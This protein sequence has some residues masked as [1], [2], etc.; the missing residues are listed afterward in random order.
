MKKTT[1]RRMDL[2]F[3]IILMMLSVWIMINCV[4]MFFNPFGREFAR[5]SGEDI[6]DSILNW[7]L[8]PAL[9]PF[10]F[11]CCLM[12][13]AIALYKIA[14]AN[15]LL[16]N[17]EMHVAVLVIAILTIY[18][19]GLIP[20]CRAALDIFPT[21]QGFPFMIATF[22]CLVAQMIVFSKKNAKKMIAAV[23][24]AAIA[25]AAVTYGFGTLA[26]IPLP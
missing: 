13:C 6:K 4:K 7:Y 15:G 5:V 1:L 18:I 26:M 22:V 23:V 21:F 19:K 8:S 11:A 24:V 3:S 2:V 14:R 17:H 12:I 16:H 20:L 25:A 9:V 10:I